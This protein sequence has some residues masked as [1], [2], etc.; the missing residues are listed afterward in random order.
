MQALHKHFLEALA[1]QLRHTAVK[2]AVRRLLVHEK[3]QAH[4]LFIADDHRLSAFIFFPV[5]LVGKI[6]LLE[7]SCRELTVTAPGRALF[8]DLPDPFS[9]DSR[10]Q[11]DLKEHFIH[12]AAAEGHLSRRLQL[13][14]SSAHDIGKVCRGGSY[15]D[16]QHRLGQNIIAHLEMLGLAGAHQRRARLGNDP[17]RRIPG[18]FEQFSVDL[19]RCFVPARRAAHVKAAVLSLNKVSAHI[20]LTQNSRREGLDVLAAFGVPQETALKP[21]LSRDGFRIVAGRFTDHELP[22]SEPG[23]GR[24]KAFRLPHCENAGNCDVVFIEI[25]DRAL[26]VSKVKSVIAIHHAPPLLT[27]GIRQVLCG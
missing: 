8:E 20:E 27:A 2:D 25:G 1:A 5:V 3:G 24:Y 16:N 17:H 15:I 13:H 21:E 19:S 12:E 23:I 7:P 11:R 10:V 14:F 22:V 4:R 9:A 18:L 26:R 6:L